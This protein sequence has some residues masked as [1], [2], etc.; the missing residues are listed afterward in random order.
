VNDFSVVC[1]WN[2]YIL[3][4]EVNYVVAFVGNHR[5][6]DV[7]ATLPHNTFTRVAKSQYSVSAADP[8]E[9]T[10]EVNSEAGGCSAEQYKVYCNAQNIEPTSMH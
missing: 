4:A 6:V 1:Q 8:I 7:V 5:L 9:C 2:W 10:G 3:G